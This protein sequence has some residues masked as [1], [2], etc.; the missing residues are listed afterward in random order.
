MGNGRFFYSRNF[1]D[2]FAHGLHR[3]IYHYFFRKFDVEIPDPEGFEALKNKDEND[4]KR[5]KIYISGR[6]SKIEQFLLN[7]LQFRLQ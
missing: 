3:R 4:K 5:L 1:V 6:N 2:S 7:G